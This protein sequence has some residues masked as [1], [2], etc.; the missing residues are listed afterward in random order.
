MRNEIYPSVVEA[1]K[2]GDTLFL[3]LGCMSAYITAICV[4]GSSCVL[5]STAVGTDVRKLAYDGYPA[6]NI[7]G[8][9]LREEYVELGYMLFR[10]KDTCPIRFFTSNVFDL[11]TSPSAPELK[12]GQS[13]DVTRVSDLSQLYD[14]LTHIY[15]GA[16]F[17]LFDKENQYGLAI[18]LARLLKR[19]PG[20]VIFGR[21]QGLESEGY[22]DDHLGRYC[23]PDELWHA[24]T[25]FAI[26]PGTD[27]G[28]R[29]VHGLPCGR[30]SSRR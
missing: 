15:T 16:L 10:D 20:A 2:T 19:E 26:A 29:R 28:T 13:L 1:G 21:H 8:C 25:N 18:R 9:D 4:S 6:S 22:I 23:D 14:S 7:L 11:P 12:E 17:H 27:M 5:T 24:C 3:D 30:P